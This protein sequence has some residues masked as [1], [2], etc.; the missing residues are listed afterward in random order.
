MDMDSLKNALLHL[1]G[2]VTMVAIADTNIMVSY[3]L[4]HWGWVTHIWVSKLT[5]IG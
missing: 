2:Y 4:T 1:I 5:I 3:R